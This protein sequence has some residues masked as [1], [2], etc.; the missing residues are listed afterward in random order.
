[1]MVGHEA[2][3]W[4]KR[5]R[6]QVVAGLRTRGRKTRQVGGAVRVGA[7][8]A[9]RRGTEGFVFGFHVGKEVGFSPP[10]AGHLGTKK[11]PSGVAPEGQSRVN[12][13]N[14]RGA[15]VTD[16]TTLAEMPVAEEARDLWPL[17][18]ICSA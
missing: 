1:M 11:S 13:Q 15:D 6:Q 5:E 16:T 12:D 9:E 17:R 4:V 2:H 18:F 10:A 7:T 3:A 14:P 8:T